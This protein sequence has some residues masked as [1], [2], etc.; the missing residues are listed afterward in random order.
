M[1]DLC[2]MFTGGAENQAHGVV[3]LLFKT[4]DKCCGCAV[5]ISGN[6]D[7][8]VSRLGWRKAT[9]QNECDAPLNNACQ[10]VADRARCIMSWPEF[11]DCCTVAGLV[12]CTFFVVA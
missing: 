5:E 9:E 7:I 1:G 3:A 11:Q 10:S 12:H 6:S 8:Q 4:M 2:V